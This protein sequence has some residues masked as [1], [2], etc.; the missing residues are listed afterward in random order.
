MSREATDDHGRWAFGAVAGGLILGPTEPAAPDGLAAPRRAM[1]AEEPALAFSTLI[2][3]PLSI[4]PVGLGWGQALHLHGSLHEFTHL[5]PQTRNFSQGA[6]QRKST[7]G[8]LLLS[9]FDT[10]TLENLRV[11]R[12]QARMSAR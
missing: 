5:C 2:G 4:F 10:S 1:A 8:D 3:G 6:K 11:A 7:W 12:K 9:V